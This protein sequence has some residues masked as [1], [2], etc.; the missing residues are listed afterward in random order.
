MNN[1]L[2]LGLLNLA[3]GNIGGIG[4]LQENIVTNWIG[5]AFLMVV[6]GIAIKFVISRQFREL[7]GFLAIAAVVALLVFAPSTVFGPQG[8]FTKL[9]DGIS[10]SLGVSGGGGSGGGAGIINL[11][12]S[13]NLL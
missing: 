10:K 7:A 11:I 5:P 6:G 13:F 2:N 9:A 12:N 4:T 8:V 3:S 1:L